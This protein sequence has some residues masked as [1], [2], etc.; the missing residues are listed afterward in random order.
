[1]TEEELQASFRSMGWGTVPK[2]RSFADALMKPPR[3]QTTMITKPMLIR[4]GIPLQPDAKGIANISKCFKFSSVQPGRTYPERNRKMMD[5][6][7]TS[8]TKTPDQWPVGGS[9]ATFHSVLIAGR[10]LAEAMATI[11]EAM[12]LHLEIDTMGTIINAER[13]GPG[14][15]TVDILLETTMIQ[16]DDSQ[17]ADYVT[18][19]HICPQRCA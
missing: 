1:M 2:V 17:I 6:K 18:T 8:T 11:N 16:R 9:S 7:H 12:R 19:V 4:G 14:V 3:V 5:V 13:A 10:P 15:R